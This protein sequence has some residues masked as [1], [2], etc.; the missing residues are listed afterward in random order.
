MQVVNTSV[1]INS[2]NLLTFEYAH[3]KYC[4]GRPLLDEAISLVEKK[5]SVAKGMASRCYPVTFHYSFIPRVPTLLQLTHGESRG[6][7]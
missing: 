3:S 1:S 6:R 2:S 5:E 4:K 7:E